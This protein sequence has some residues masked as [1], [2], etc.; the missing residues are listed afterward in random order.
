MVPRRIVSFLVFVLPVLVVAFAI[1]MA[2]FALT[3]A[4]GDATAAAVFWWIAIATLM[5]L[6]GDVLLLVICLGVNYL[7]ESDERHH[8][9]TGE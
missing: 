4:T 8:D 5:V 3:Q 2:G 1:L 7:A 9:S 6:V